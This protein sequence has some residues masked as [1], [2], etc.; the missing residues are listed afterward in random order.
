MTRADICRWPGLVLLAAGGAALL[1]LTSTTSASASPDG[2]T[3]LVMAGTQGCCVT[4]SQLQ[5]V[6]PAF[7]PDYLQDA[8]HF[9]D[10]FF[11]DYV[12]QFLTTNEQF[13]PFTGLQS[14]G[15]D[16]AT[17]QTVTLMTEAVD[18][19]IGEGNDVVVFGYSHSTAAIT[20]YEDQLAAL[21]ADDR[22]TP[23]QL[24]FVQIGDVDNPNGGILER[25]AG[26]YAP[27]LDLYGY[28][29]QPD[30]LYPSAIYTFQYDGFADFP[31]YPLNILADINALFGGVTVHGYY[32]FLSAAEISAVASVPE[33]VTPADT[34]TTYLMIPNPNLPLLQV[35]EATVPGGLPAPLVDLIEPPLR[36]IIDLGYDPTAPANVPTPG[37]LFPDV[38][39]LGALIGLGQSIGQGVNDFLAAEGMPALPSVPL[40]S[41][42]VNDLAASPLATDTFSLPTLTFPVPL[43]VGEVVD[44]PLNALNSVV[45]AG[46]DNGLDSANQSLVNVVG[47]ALTVVATEADAPEKVMNAIYVGQQ[48][49]PILLDAPGLVV[50]VATQDLVSGLEDLV[51]GNLSGF[52]QQIQDVVTQNIT[53]GSFE[54]FFAYAALEDIATGA[55]L[56]IG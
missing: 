4:P 47:S 32:P 3:E 37:Q 2:D 13:Y 55:V 8:T 54:G 18:K 7:Y 26:V 15:F 50:T 35:L 14:I 49:A 53:L 22:P 43:Q 20:A 12:P 24:D 19:Q 28:G 39:P 23:D 46:I 31:Q 48:L 40:V 51:A 25:L 29:A 30:D 42:L 33:P 6:A 17:S 41:H 38:N 9:T 36:Y 27:S 10:P 45:A 52:S 34:D 11:K 1:G 16:Q 21:P 44:V 5:T 56:T